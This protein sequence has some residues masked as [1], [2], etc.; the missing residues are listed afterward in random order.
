MKAR[1]P[2]QLYFRHPMT[3]TGDTPEKKAAIEQFLAARGYKVTP[4]TIENSDFIFNVPYAQARHQN[5][6]AL[7][8]R[9]RDAYLDFSMAATQFAENISPQMFGREIPQIL[10]IHANDLNAEALDEL[11]TRCEA[12]GYRFV[13]L[14]QAMADPAYQTRDTWVGKMGP[15]WFMRWS[16]GQVAEVAS[17]TVGLLTLPERYPQDENNIR[18]L[19]PDLDHPRKRNGCKSSIQ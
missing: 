12:R 5:D 8:K 16:G 1:G 17:L 15:T 19:R 11:L 6:L 14:D 2:Y 10:L 4:H 13:S 3:H 18:D 9:L 7:A